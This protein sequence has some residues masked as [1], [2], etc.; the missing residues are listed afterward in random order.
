M[1][2]LLSPS[3]LSSLFPSNPRRPSQCRRHGYSSRL[4]VS[5]ERSDTNASSNRSSTA[6]IWF[7]HD[8][9]VDDHPG[10]IAASR[11]NAVVPLYVF[12]RRI[13][14]R[15]TDEMLELLLLAV[16]D[17]K[18]LLNDYGSDLLIRVG[19]VERV[20]QDIVKEVD[21]T[22]V[23]AEAEVEYELCQMMDMVQDAIKSV[24]LLYGNPQVNIWN[25]PLHDNMNLKDLP[26]SYRDFKKLNFPIMSPQ[27]PPTL[28]SVKM[29]LNWGSMPSMDDLRSFLGNNPPKSQVDWTSIKEISAETILSDSQF[30]SSNMNV[31]GRIANPKSGEI[32]QKSSYKPSKGKNFK[33][34][35]AGQ[36][37]DL[38]G[39]GTEIVLDALAAYLR[40]LEGTVRDDWQE[41]HE[42]LRNA[43]IRQGASFRSLFGSA[44][45]LGIISRRRAY[46]EAIK[47]EKER[48]AGFLS[49][50]GYSTPTVA[51]V[52]ETVCSMEWY[53]LMAI[54]GQSITKEPCH[55]RIWRWK[56]Y[57][58]Q[59]TVVGH[60]GPAV[61]LVHGFGAFL[62]HYR[63]N[64]NNI[65]ENGMRVWALTLLGFGKS[66]KPNVI[67]TEIMWAELLRDFIVE[68]V[69]EPVHLVG[70]SLGGYLISIVAGLW[71]VLAM[72][73]VL[74]NSAGNVVPGY[75]S[76]RFTRERKTSGVTRL[77]AQFISLY[78]RW[79]IK[80]I[81]TNCYPTV[82]SRADDW[83]INEMIR[84][85]N[86]PGVEVVLESIFSFNISIPLNYL[87]KGFNNRV[88]VIQGMKDPIAD[89]KSV[90][91]MLRE[92]CEGI[93]IKELDAGHCPHDE[94][95]ETVNA[96]IKEWVFSIGGKTLTC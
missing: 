95:P 5:M 4:V 23:Y 41:L 89:S 56:G 74:I 62:E 53:W 60:E 3:F 9:R 57:L 59:F 45:S 96:I 84:S 19:R 69:R 88:L 83:L 52:I 66:E 67:Y 72:S 21:A 70:N 31:N 7:K 80:S 58:I 34:L 65:A 51:A 93:T 87:L 78:L 61:L 49:P 38:I 40:Y 1:A 63:D 46:Y 24:S 13:L 44:F 82:A 33:S 16:N 48:N 10:L 42:K 75:S 28:S 85:S 36:G 43:E 2:S 77:G 11:S 17:L 6:V 15:F 35:F 86:D 54:K 90:I 73:V 68:V 55:I 20:I 25:A 18:K 71:P 92:H 94:C 64:I 50:F 30:L 27:L 14:S 37:K 29:N 26:S 39:G 76:V 81:V 8:L 22:D 12:D 32:V 91:A 47:Y 79:T